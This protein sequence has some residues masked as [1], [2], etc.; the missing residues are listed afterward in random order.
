MR[1]R[2]RFI[3]IAAAFIAIVSTQA[4]AAEH[5]VM[6]RESVIYISPSTSAAKLLNITRGREVAVLERSNGWA[7]VF[8]T[9]DQ[10]FGGDRDISGWVQDRGLITAATPNGDQILFGEAVDSEAQAS[11]RGGRKGAAQDA[12]RLYARCAE[13]FPQSEIS[14]E[15]LF[16]SADIRW[17]L[18]KE[19]Q[20]GRKSSKTADPRDRLPIEDHFMK[21]VIK[22]Y[23][24][25][26]WSDLA[27]FALLDNKLCGDW[28]SQ[29]KC[30]EKEA[31]LYEDYAKEHPQS[32]KVA[33]ALYNAAIR[34][35]SL[36]EIYKVEGQVAKSQPSAQRAIA[37]SQKV[38]SGNPSQDWAARAYRLIYMVE[39]N[40]P[41]YGNS[42]D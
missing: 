5:G 1:M 11:Q 35:A 6:V 38:L 23:P 33:E 20:R 13:Y 8:A 19:D 15:A 34:Y 32:P 14:G 42:V 16:R 37:T 30:P 28:L 26:K 4:V 31:A 2:N 27:A 12:M 24:R 3:G 36:I 7:H 21:E 29:S 25:S 40:I 9:V 10:S 17:Q 18:D 41:V 39:N 22:K